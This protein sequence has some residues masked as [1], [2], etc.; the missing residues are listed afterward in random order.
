MAKTVKQ[1]LRD[2]LWMINNLDQAL[3]ELRYYLDHKN[4]FKGRPLRMWT[5]D[6]DEGLFKIE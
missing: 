6:E 3:K 5:L 4:D 1:K 2:R